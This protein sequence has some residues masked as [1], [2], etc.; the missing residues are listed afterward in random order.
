MR[1]PRPLQRQ[2]TTPAVSSSLSHLSNETIISDFARTFAGG[3]RNRLPDVGQCL[4]ELTG[5]IRAAARERSPEHETGG[6]LF[7]ELD[8]TLGIAWVT[9]VSG[10]PQDSDFSAEHFVCGTRG[11]ADLCKD[12]THRTRGIVHYVGTWHSHLS[13]LQGPAPPTMRASAPSSQQRPT[14][15]HINSW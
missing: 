9:N 10:P 1:W 14:T 15:A 6:L 11:T 2:T 7:G 3:R 13:A 5:W 12:Y 4:G 8:E